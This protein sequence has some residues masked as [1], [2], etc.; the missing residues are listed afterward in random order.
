MT[1]TDWLCANI[2]ITPTITRKYDPSFR[3]SRTG[4]YDTAVLPGTSIYLCVF[5]STVASLGVLQRMIRHNDI[6]PAT[7]SVRQHQ[8]QAPAALPSSSTHLSRHILFYPLYFT[9]VLVINT[10][11]SL[12]VNSPHCLGQQDGHTDEPVYMY[13]FV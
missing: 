12:S 2:S 9:V 8:A 13:D 3:L 5:C 7:G 6:P 10:S 4:T 11:F 1:H